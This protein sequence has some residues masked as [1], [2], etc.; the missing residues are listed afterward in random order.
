MAETNFETRFQPQIAPIQNHGTFLWTVIPETN[1]IFLESVIFQLQDCM[2][3]LFSEQ[4]LNSYGHC[5]DL[6]VKIALSHHYV[7]KR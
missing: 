7:E 2:L 4:S 1:L 3:S 6:E 5:S